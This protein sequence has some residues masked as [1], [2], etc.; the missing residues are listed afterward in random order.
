MDIFLDS[1]SFRK[2]ANNPTKFVSKQEKNE[3]LA[4][5]PVVSVIPPY[6]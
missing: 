3:K 5:C 6:L 2:F 4:I 1:E